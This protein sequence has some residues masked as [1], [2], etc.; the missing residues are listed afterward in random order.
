MYLRPCSIYFIKEK[1][2]ERSISYGDIASKAVSIEIPEEVELKE[3]SD[4]P[5]RQ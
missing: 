5:G 4:F 3:I 2:G 1:N